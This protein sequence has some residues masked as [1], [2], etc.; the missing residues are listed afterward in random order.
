MLNDNV[1]E[2]DIRRIRNER[3][4]AGVEGDSKAGIVSLQI[5]VLQEY[6][7]KALGSHR[8]RCLNHDVAQN[9]RPSTLNENGQTIDKATIRQRRSYAAYHQ[10]S[11]VSGSFAVHNAITA[12]IATNPK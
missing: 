3:A 2:V 8:T 5:A 11:I 7:A 10:L 12:L 4:A 6:G 1:L 9:Q